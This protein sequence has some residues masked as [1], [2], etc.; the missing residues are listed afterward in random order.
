MSTTVQIGKYVL[1]PATARDRTLVEFW[2]R[3]DP[4]HRETTKAD[5]FLKDTDQAECFAMEDEFGLV[6]FYIKMTRQIDPRQ[7]SITL[8]LDIQFGPA[9]T[10]EAKRR[11]GD[12][13]FEGFMWLSV[14]CSGAGI[15][16]LRF[17]SQNP[18]LIT[19]AK[20]RLG[21]QGAPED[22]FFTIP[23]STLKSAE[24]NPLQ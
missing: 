21:F 12:A 13:L 17:N 19:F 10:I 23:P 3:N 20:T 7:A 6:V 15:S 4:D 2:I 9:S 14:A 22:L 16:A 8:V 11:I 1:R 18:G 24:E 5:F